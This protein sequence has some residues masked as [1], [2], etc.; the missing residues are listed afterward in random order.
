MAGG[1]Y[2]YTKKGHARHFGEILATAGIESGFCHAAVVV[3]LRWSKNRISSQPRPAPK[4]PGKCRALCKMLRR[5][6]R[7]GCIHTGPCI[8]FRSAPGR[9][10]GRRRAV[11]RAESHA[12]EGRYLCRWIGRDATAGTKTHAAA[13]CPFV[14][15]IPVA[16][17]RRAGRKGG[18]LGARHPPCRTQ[19]DMARLLRLSGRVWSEWAQTPPGAGF[20]LPLSG[21]RRGRIVRAVNIRHRPNER[22]LPTGGHIGTTAPL[23]VQKGLATA[24]VALTLREC[25]R[26]GIARVLLVC[27]KGNPASARIIA[28]TAAG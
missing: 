6:L 16:D 1:M 24:M 22:P 19:E 28:Q 12:G 17:A 13:V 26:P 21:R 4:A 11:A 15:G 14:R 9:A 3:L 5:F 18:H 25:R 20:R 10:T 2:P 27:R 8:A 23:Q 7:H